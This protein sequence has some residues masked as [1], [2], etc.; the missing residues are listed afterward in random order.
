MTIKSRFQIP[1][2]IVKR[3]AAALL[4]LIIALF[5]TSC[6]SREVTFQSQQEN[7]RPYT[8]DIT[9]EGGSGKAYVE[10]PVEIFE[11]D[12]V[13]YARLVWN[14]ENYDYVIVDGDTYLNE[15]PGGKSSFTVPVKSLDEPF[16]FIADTVAMSKPHEIEYTITWGAT[17]RTGSLQTGKVS[18]S[19]NDG[20]PENAVFGRR[21]EE[22]AEYLVDGKSYSGRILLSY[23][24]GFDIIKYDDY[25]LIRIYGADDYLLVPEGKPEPEI[26]DAETGDTVNI[27]ILRQPLDKTYLVSTS[28]MDLIRQ[29]GALDMI[30]LS[31]TREEDW[32]VKEAADLMREGK[33][34]YAGKYRTPDYELILSD[35]C[36]L[37]IENTMIYHD[38]AVKEKLEELSVPVL[39]ETSSYERDPIGRLEWIKLYGTLYGKEKESEDDFRQC[40]K[41]IKQ[42][43]E[44][45][46]T[47]KKVAFFSVSASGL[48][49]V[50]RPGDYI[51]NLIVLA[52]GDYVPD[53]SNVSMEGVSGTINMQM[54]DF[55]AG[56]CDA[57]I[58]IYNSTIQGGIGSVSDLIG[59]NP[60]FAD[61]AA[62]K[63]RNV[64]CTSGDFFQHPTETAG[65]LSDLR[66]LTEG[67]AALN[68]F[69]EKLK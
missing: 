19:G 51:T 8:V 12:R 52:G 1:N 58:L 44:S 49:T 29:I 21:P 34:V 14:S 62:V 17:G 28:V 32:S 9:M 15:N 39:V 41:E 63:D 47:G 55:Y 2:K 40:E 67:N 66:N 48:I 6:T 38:P 25:R 57:D 10:S 7:T 24:E 13:T 30:S 35:G 65:Y 50:R 46:K 69:F 5:V 3:A 27:T 36:N 53:Y 16:R 42:V 56:T 37:A 23:A 54:E 18:Q 22:S 20:E 45:G 26:T 68:G 59:L 11:K 61:F 60:L 64:Y 43:I 31:G 4:P 33:I